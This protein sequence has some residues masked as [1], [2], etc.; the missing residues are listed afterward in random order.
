MLPASLRR[1]ARS[2]SRSCARCRRDRLTLAMVVGIPLLQMLIFGYGINYDVRHIRAGVVDLANTQASRSLIAESHRARWSISSRM[3]A[4]AEELRRLIVAG[5]IAWACTSRRF[6][7]APD[8]GDRGRA[9][10][11]IVDGTRPGVDTRYAPS[12]KRRSGTRGRWYR[13][14]TPAIEVLHRIQP[15]RRTAVHVVPA[16]IGVILSMTMVIF[17]AIALV[18]ERERG[19]LEVLIATPMRS[20]RADDRQDPAVHRRR[21][22]QMT[23]VL[24]V[25]VLLFSVPI[26]GSLFNLYLGAGCSSRRRWRSGC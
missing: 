13:R 11:C 3:P 26:N 25:G 15:E 14:A 20:D 24:L 1:R 12:P 8:R 7:A 21:L 9:R 4:G 18:R 22:M 6:R 16:L 17:T 10:R 2:P 5:G 19:N 23:L